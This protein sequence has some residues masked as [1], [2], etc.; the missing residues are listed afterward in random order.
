M[1]PGRRSRG[2]PPPAS[3]SSWPAPRLWFAAPGAA[4]AVVPSR[5]SP[6][7]SDRRGRGRGGVQQRHDAASRAAGPPRTAVRDRLGASAMSAGSSRSCSCSGFLAPIRETGKTYLGLNPLFGLD[8]ARR[9]GDRIVGPFAAVWFLRLRRCR[10]SCSRRTCRG[11]DAG[12]RMRS[13]AGLARLRS[14]I[15]E[16]RRDAALRASSSPTWSIRTGWWRCSP[17]GASTARACSAGARS[18]SGSSASC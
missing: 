1:R 18:S 15:A 3:S 14:T 16:A 4:H 5:S 6:S 2:S 10:C 13:R 17:S 8:P 7:R 9:E 12:P 11:A